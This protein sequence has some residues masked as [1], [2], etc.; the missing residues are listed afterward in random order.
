MMRK[1]G[2][3]VE[4]WAAQ[5]NRRGPPQVCGEVGI[6]YASAISA[7][8]LASVTPPH[9]VT[10]YMATAHALRSKNGRYSS[11]VAR[12]SLKQTGTLVLLPSSPSPS[13]LALSLTS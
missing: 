9:Q 11:R 1:L 8:F 6:E 7:I 10:S 12:V 2:T 13:P 4:R 5:I 3:A